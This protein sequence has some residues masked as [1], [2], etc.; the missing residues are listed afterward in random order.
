M[1][2]HC[3]GDMWVQKS[4]FPGLLREI[5]TSF[6]IGGKGYGGLGRNPFTNGQFKD[7]WEYDP[8][9]DFWIQKANRPTDSYGS[10]G[11]TILG[12]G[13]SVG[14]VLPLTCQCWEYDPIHDT[15]TQKADYPGIGGGFLGAQFQI[16]N[17]WYV[18]L[19]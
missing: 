18:G 8:I 5:P 11:F 4:S 16:N 13:Y 19:G 12:K 1:N 7:H 10:S 15:W 2:F 9:T 3:F 14:D 17:K 6:S